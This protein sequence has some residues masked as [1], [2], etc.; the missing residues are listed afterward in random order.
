MKLNLLMK[1]KGFMKA[2]EL[3]RPGVAFRKFHLKNGTVLWT[4][5]HMHGDRRRVCI[6]RKSKWKEYKSYIKPHT[7][8]V[9]AVY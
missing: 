1:K 2:H 7:E 9:I 4:K 6:S 8:V 5:A 3:T